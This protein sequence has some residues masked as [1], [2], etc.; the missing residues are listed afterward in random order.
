MCNSEIQ[1]RP[2]NFLPIFDSETYLALKPN[3]NWTDVIVCVGFI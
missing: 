1:K 2:E 3:L